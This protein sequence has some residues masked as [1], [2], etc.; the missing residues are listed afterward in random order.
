MRWTL[1]SIMPGTQ[2]LPWSSR[3]MSAGPARGTGARRLVT[4][5]LALSSTCSTPTGSKATQL[6]TS[7]RLAPM[8]TTPSK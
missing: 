6:E 7:Q 5:P 8:F 3:K 2:S 1:P 4:W